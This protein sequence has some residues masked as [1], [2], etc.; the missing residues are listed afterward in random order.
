MFRVFQFLVIAGVLI[1][2]APAFAQM[3]AVS[4]NYGINSID[5]DGDGK[6]EHV[7]KSWRENF[8]AHGYHAYL[9][10][11]DRK[12]HQGQITSSITVLAPEKGLHRDMARSS[13]GADCTVTDY[14]LIKK[15]D[16]Q[17]LEL[18]KTSRPT[19][20]GYGGKHIVTFEFYKLTRNDEGIPGDPHRY[21]QRYKT[22]TS[23]QKYCDVHNAVK[24]ELLQ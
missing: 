3:K 12:S 4:L 1:S 11:E 5:L 2:T 6:A 8:N 19:T 14:I 13:E 7:I 20:N 16:D 24:A 22:I 23:K 21:W 15:N 17:A 18:L 9:Y 10:L